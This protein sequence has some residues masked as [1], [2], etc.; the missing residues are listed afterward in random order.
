MKCTKCDTPVGPSDK[1]CRFCGTEIANEIIDIIEEKKEVDIIDII[2]IN[3]E[4]DFEK[5]GIIDVVSIKKEIIEEKIDHEVIELT[6]PKSVLKGKKIKEFDL[7]DELEKTGIFSPVDMQEFTGELNITADIEK[8]EIKETVKEEIKNEIVTTIDI[9]KNEEPDETF[10]IKL[11]P[12]VVLVGVLMISLVLNGFQFLN[13]DVSALA[14]NNEITEELKT[15]YLNDYKIELPSNWDISVDSLQDNLVI[16]DSAKNWG[17]SIS[18]L[19][20]SKKIDLDNKKEEIKDIFT[21]NGYIFTSDITKNI[22][23]SESHIFKGKY[24]LYVVYVVITK[25]NDNEIIISDLKFKGAVNT[26]IYNTLLDKVSQIKDGEMTNFKSSNFNFDS[27][28]DKII[29]ELNKEQ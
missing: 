22:N 28:N 29:D 10:K 14:G 2:D 21:K 4:I 18:L 8:A 3:E 13:R 26:E 11:I 5:T 17:A 25:I 16:L 1:R 7:A 24:E 20:S 27:F 23:N 9:P 19:K 15:T 6:T 12:S